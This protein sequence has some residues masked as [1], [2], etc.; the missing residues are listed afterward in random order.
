MFWS[1][2]E[3]WTFVWFWG[4]QPHEAESEL[5]LRKSVLDDVDGDGDGDG[6]GGRVGG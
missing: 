5:S 1:F 3:F 2:G 6:V 4:P